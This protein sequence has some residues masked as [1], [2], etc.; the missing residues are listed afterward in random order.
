MDDFK[1]RTFAAKLGI[2]FTGT[3]GIFIEAKLS[4]QIKSVRDILEKIKKTD[5]RISFELEQLVLQL[6]Q[7]I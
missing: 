5:F 2:R 1:G 6:S 7:E 3:L 4:G